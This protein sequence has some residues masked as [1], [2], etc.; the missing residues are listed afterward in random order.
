MR[1]VTYVVI[2]SAAGVA[3]ALGQTNSAGDIIGRVVS[4]TGFGVS[5]ATVLVA[6][7]NRAGT[8]PFVRHAT[9]DGNGNFAVT[10]VTTGQNVVCVRAPGYLDPCQSGNGASVD[11]EG[12]QLQVELTMP[13]GRRIEVAIRDSNNVLN[14]TSAT[15]GLVVHLIYDGGTQQLL[16]LAIRSGKYF[17]FAGD[18]APG[19]TMT[20]EVLGSGFTFRQGGQTVN[21][22]VSTTVVAPTTRSATGRHLPFSP[23]AGSRP[24]LRVD[25]EVVGKL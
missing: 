1:T 14:A 12:K 24:D 18:V 8:G 2:L 21:S 11:F 16:P 9:T 4:T 20:V 10:G 7:A 17:V 19:A 15:S 3:S 25:F 5:A 22:A 13:E 23:P 6:Q